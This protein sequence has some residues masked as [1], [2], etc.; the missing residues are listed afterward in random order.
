[1]EWSS[2][3]DAP[4]CVFDDF[5]DMKQYLEFKYGKSGIQHDRFERLSK[6]GTSSFLG[7]L[8][9]IVGYNRAGLEGS[10]LSIHQLIDVYV[11]DQPK[12]Y[13]MIPNLRTGE[14]EPHPKAKEGGN[15]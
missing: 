10:S 6:K 11:H 14:L 3:V 5:D 8:K 13:G 1:M 12:M 9:D 4:I 7:E 2:I 15:Q